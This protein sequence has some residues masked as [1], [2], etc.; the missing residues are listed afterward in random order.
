MELAYTSIGMSCQQG[1]GATPGLF[2]TSVVLQLRTKQ[3][4][5]TEKILEGLTKPV[6]VFISQ[7]TIP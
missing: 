7:K 5:E 4:L 2:G 3:K 6:D 1:T